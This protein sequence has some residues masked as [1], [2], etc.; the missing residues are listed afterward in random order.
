MQAQ[1]ISFSKD[2]T[3]VGNI[4]GEVGVQ[5]GRAKCPEKSLYILLNIA[6]NLKKSFEK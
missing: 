2:T 3:L 1:C 6:V 4:V 5:L